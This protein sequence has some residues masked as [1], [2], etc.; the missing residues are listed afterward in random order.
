MT[1]RFHGA[2]IMMTEN[3]DGFSVCLI[4]FIIFNEKLKKVRAILVSLSPIPVHNTNNLHKHAYDVMRN[5]H[6]YRVIYG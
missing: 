6:R 4:L 1:D 5:T 3:M 2:M